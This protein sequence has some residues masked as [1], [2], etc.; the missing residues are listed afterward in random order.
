MPI[1]RRTANIAR[2]RSLSVQSALVRN[3]ETPAASRISTTWRAERFFGVACSKVGRGIRRGMRPIT[4]G[5]SACWGPVVHVERES[6]GM[7]HPEGLASG[8]S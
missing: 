1:S 6:P 5:R 3:S 8:P 7:I 4:P 2:S